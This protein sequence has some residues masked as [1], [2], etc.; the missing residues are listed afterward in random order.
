MEKSVP[1][2]TQNMESAPEEIQNE[3]NQEISINYVYT[4]IIWNQ[5]DMEN[6]DETFSYTV[7]CDITNGNEDPEPRSVVECQRRNDWIKWKDAMQVELNSLSKRKVFGVIVLKP[8]AVKPVGYK[9]VFVRKRNE[10]NEIVRYKAQ[11]V[12]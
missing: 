2:E 1:E 11:L 6:V 7:S 4:G 12:A 5:N 10:K 8:E 9:L 3:I